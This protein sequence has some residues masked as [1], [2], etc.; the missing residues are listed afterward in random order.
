MMVST[1]RPVSQK[2]GDPVKS[3]PTAQ[4]TC[5][6][7]GPLRGSPPTLAPGMAER[8]SD[9][10]FAYSDQFVNAKEGKCPQGYSKG[11]KHPLCKQAQFYAWERGGR[12]TNRG[13]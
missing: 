11:D 3:H 2:Y 5:A 13:N 4:S 8:D 6:L 9:R 10:H 12:D 7:C 1:T